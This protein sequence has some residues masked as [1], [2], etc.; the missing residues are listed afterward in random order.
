MV[1][2]KNRICIYSISKIILMTRLQES[3]KFYHVTKHDKYYD[4][5]FIDCQGYCVILSLEIE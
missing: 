3:N 5:N 4:I 1:N 2:I